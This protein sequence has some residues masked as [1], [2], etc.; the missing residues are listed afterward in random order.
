MRSLSFAAVSVVILAAFASA[1]LSTAPCDFTAAVG[2]CASATQTRCGQ[3]RCLAR[4]CPSEISMSQAIRTCSAAE[5]REALYPATNAEAGN[6]HK[7]TRD[8]DDS[9]AKPTAAAAASPA[10][11][12]PLGTPR[13]ESRCLNVSAQWNV[14]NVRAMLYSF[15]LDVYAGRSQE[16]YSE[17]MTLRWVG[18]HDGI[19]APNVPRYSDCSSMVTWLYWNLFG[20][21]ADFLNGENWGA[22]YTGSLKEHGVAVGTDPSGLK[23]GDLCFYY[24]PMHH[25][26]IYVGGNMV[27]THGMDPVGYYAYNYAPLD[28]CR[29]YLE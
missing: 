13:V 19:C 27:V 28:F 18:I 2:K 26:A 1:S 6:A 29:R 14:E 16:T 7:F 9:Y 21:G 23:V 3:W 8:G 5:G 24:H 17:N 12:K 25:V 10:S 22:G 11:I 15:A 20:N 4:E